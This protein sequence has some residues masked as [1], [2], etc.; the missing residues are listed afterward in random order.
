VVALALATAA[1]AG[2]GQRTSETFQ[3]SDPFSGSFDCGAFT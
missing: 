3:F 1:A 2:A